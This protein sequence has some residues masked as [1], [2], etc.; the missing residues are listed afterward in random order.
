MWF[1]SITYNIYHDSCL[2]SW[3]EA[4]W[5]VVAL[6]SRNTSRHLWRD[7]AVAL[8]WGTLEASAESTLWHLRE[9]QLPDIPGRL[10]KKVHIHTWNIKKGSVTAQWSR[11]GNHILSWLQYHTINYHLISFRPQLNSS[12][13]SDSRIHSSYSFSYGIS[14]GSYTATIYAAAYCCNH[15]ETDECPLSFVAIL[16]A[17][18]SAP[19]RTCVDLSNCTTPHPSPFASFFLRYGPGS[20]A[21]ESVAA[22][23]ALALEISTSIST[24]TDHQHQPTPIPV[25]YRISTHETIHLI[26]GISH[27]HLQLSFITTT[28]DPFHSI[29]STLIQCSHAPPSHHG[30]GP[31]LRTL[32]PGR[33]SSRNP[34]TY[35]LLPRFIR[36]QR[37]N[38]TK[39]LHFRSP[40]LLPLQTRRSKILA[41]PLLGRN[42]QPRPN[43]TSLHLRRRRRNNRFRPGSPYKRMFSINASSLP[44]QS[45]RPIPPPHSPR[46]KPEL[47]R[48]QIHPSPNIMGHQTSSRTHRPRPLKRWSNRSKPPR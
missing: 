3:P 43:S 37:L 33:S 9:H 39:S 41:S 34:P 10:F 4:W 1:T 32:R 6:G 11:R 35:L 14:Q 19:T 28:I 31:R 40:Y 27:A 36:P 46:Y 7:L 45:G 29:Q 12:Q 38:P 2:L 24:D 30:P 47:S 13:F 44:W 18:R 17:R 22:A 48:S 25:H 23:S 26:L 16:V 42:P 5:R 21:P 20:D 15:F 8:R